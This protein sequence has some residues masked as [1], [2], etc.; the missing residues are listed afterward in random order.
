MDKQPRIQTVRTAQTQHTSVGKTNDCG[1]KRHRL[2]FLVLVWFDLNYF[3]VTGDIKTVTP[4]L[5]YRFI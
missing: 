5:F 1:S 4:S 3:S 2:V